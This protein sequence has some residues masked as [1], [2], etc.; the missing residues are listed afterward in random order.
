LF[1]FQINNGDWAKGT[2]H[3]SAVEEGIL[4]RLKRLYADTEKPLP[5]DLAAVYRLARARDRAEKQ[6]V[7]AMLAEQFVLADGGYSNVELD[8]QIER[9]RAK[10]TKAKASANAR[11]QHKTDDANAMRTHADNDANAMQTDMRT[12]SERNADAMLTVN[13]K[14]ETENRKPKTHTTQPATTVDTTDAGFVCFWE[15][16]PA[17]KR[18]VGKDQCLKLWVANNLDAKQAQIMAA[19]NEDIASEEWTKDE[20][21]FV[22]KPLT[23]L[24]EER[25]ERE[26]P[27]QPPKPVCKVCGD[28]A[29]YKRDGSEYCRTHFMDSRDED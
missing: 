23:W 26:T 19:L 4:F 6:A 16:Y 12:H 21:L 25:Y 9:Y 13:R 27:T 2:A 3:L 20:G 24:S 5:S 15:K 29:T 17:T 7:V 8:A 18:K 28:P 14:P 10:N 22:C 11:W 1:Y